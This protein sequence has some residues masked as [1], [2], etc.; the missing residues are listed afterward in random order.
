LTDSSNEGSTGSSSGEEEGDDEDI[1]GE[2]NSRG[3][4]QDS[5]G[6]EGPGMESSDDAEDD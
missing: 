2:E 4:H 5:D 6:N 3:S 1:Q